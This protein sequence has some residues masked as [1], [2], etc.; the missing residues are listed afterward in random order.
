M[1]RESIHPWWHPSILGCFPCHP[2]ALAE[3]IVKSIATGHRIVLKSNVGFEIQKINIFQVGRSS[4]GPLLFSAR[5]LTRSKMATR[6][7]VLRRASAIRQGI[8][9]CYLEL[10]TNGLELFCWVFWLSLVCLQKILFIEISG[11]MLWD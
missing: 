9:S 4:G 2:L 6:K 5:Y 11:D 10:Q 3:V 7:V 8:R 1:S